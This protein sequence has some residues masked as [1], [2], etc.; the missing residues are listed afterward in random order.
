MKANARLLVC[1]L[2]AILCCGGVQAQNKKIYL[3]S[4]SSRYPNERPIWSEKQAQ[5]WFD[6]HSPIKGINHP[7]PPCDAVSQD[8]ALQRA[9][10]IGYNSVRWWPNSW[11]YINSVDNYATIAAKH[12]INCAPVFGF[13]HVPTSASDSTSMEKKVRE[14]IRYFRGDERIIMWDIWN[15]PLMSGEDCRDQMKWIRIIAQWCREEGCTQAIT[16]SILW[17]PDISAAKENAY[18]SVRRE[19]EKE[20]DL[21]N[22][23]DYVMQESHSAN[24]TYVMN[25]FKKIDNRPLVCTECLTRPDGSGMAITL[26]E[27]SKHKIGFYTWGLYASDP[28]WEIKWGRSAYYAY[29]PMFHNILYAGGDPVNEQEL[30]CVKNFRFQEG[31]ESIYPGKEITE[32]WT[33]RRAWKW[34]NDTPLKGIKL[35][36]LDEAAEWLNQHASDGVYNT[37]TVNLS[38]KQYNQTGITAYG[39]KLGALAAKANN[40]GIK[41][42]PVFFKSGEL[43]SSKQYMAQYISNIMGKFY[44]DRRFEGWC[45][46]DQTSTDE[47]SDYKNVFQYIFSYV[48]YVFPNQPMFAAPMLDASQQADS[49]AADFNNYMW[50]LSD[51]VAFNTPDGAEVSSSQLENLFTAYER[52]LFFMNN[53]KMKECFAHLLVYCVAEVQIDAI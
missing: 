13:T 42:I 3:A 40:A 15:E 46:F 24:I 37:M 11:D 14:I 2:A 51:V 41:L 34:M 32:R 22:F 36:S 5:E 47:P 35:N 30:E 31:S 52:P 9:A 29:E 39:E 18:T 48:R 45:L 28:N 23:H 7:E 19:A 38:Y 6:K 33:K 16:S 26:S 20:M 44:K 25:R 27:F 4:S 8:E 43:A 53:R 12:G 21:H 17:D 10:Q 49:T 1:A 50:Q